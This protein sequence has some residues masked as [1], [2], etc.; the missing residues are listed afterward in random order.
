M[1]RRRPPTPCRRPRSIETPAA[2]RRC[3]P[4]VARATAARRGRAPQVKYYPIVGG[5]LR[6]HVGDVK[7]VDDVS[8]AVRN[9][10]DLRPRR[11]VGLRQVDPRARRSSGSSRRPAG[12][13]RARRRGHLRQEGQGAQEA[14]PPDAD[15]LPGPGRVA[16][17]ADA[18]QRHHRRGAAGPGRRPR[19]S[20]ATARSATSASGTTSRRSACGATTPGATRTSSPA[21]SGS[22]SASPGRWRSTRTSSSATSR[23]RRSTCRSSRQIL[24]LLLDLRTRVQPDLP[25]HRPQPVR[26]P[27][28]QRPGRGDVPGQA[29]RAGRGGGALPAPAPPVHGR[30]PV[31]GPGRRPAHPQEAPRPAGRRAVAGGAADRAAGSTPAAGCASSSATRRTAR[32]IDPE[33]RDIGDDHLVACHWAE[34]VPISVVA[35]AVPTAEATPDVAAEPPA[36]V[37]AGGPPTDAGAPAGGSTSS[38]I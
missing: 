37:P 1:P 9:G 13:A 17:P 14:A 2:A 24:N 19:T 8:F 3:P 10:R 23:S 21:A 32:P 12:E 5:L 20:G 7:A 33:F 28:H 11:R 6:A 30:A 16:E 34:K 35:D 27:V 38:G 36:G 15:H 18:D 29:R 26:R 4:R 31:G 22:G 25:V